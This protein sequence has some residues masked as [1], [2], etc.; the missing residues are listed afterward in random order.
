MK[1]S[2]APGA[3]RK[4][5]MLDH[6]YRVYEKLAVPDNIACKR[7]C[8]PCC[9][10]NVTLTGL[11][12]VRIAGYI[13]T[14]GKTELIDAVKAASGRKR[15]QPGFT[16]NQMADFFMRGE[17]I[18][19]EEI[20]PAWGVCPLLE[21]DECMV[22]P[23]RPFGCRC[24]ISAV[25][26][27]ETGYA[28]MTEFTAAVNMVFLQY[29]EHVDAGGYFGN[30][31]DMLLYLLENGNL[32]NCCEGIQGNRPENLI[33]S[34]PLHFLMVPP[35]FREKIRPILQALEHPL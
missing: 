4:E 35:E 29:I 12:A 32:E 22:Y 10:C 6:I 17:D 7:G 16:T 3:Y 1:N 20:D 31:T 24:M 13:L 19:E 11:E 2:F 34:Q 27:R 25:N 14:E 26:C 5:A 23:V 8:S 15:F 9:T 21:N 18:P 28:D 30:L 33:V